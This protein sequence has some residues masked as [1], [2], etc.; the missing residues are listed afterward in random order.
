M[1]E[2]VDSL[3]IGQGLAGSLL[4]WRLLQRGERVVVVDN[5]H[6]SSSSTVAAG[7]INPVTG[8]RLVKTVGVDETLPVARESYREL[9]QLLGLELLVEKPMLRLFHSAQERERW[10]KRLTEEGYRPYLGEMLE[11]E[12]L[13]PPVTASHGGGRQ[14][15]TAYLRTTP[16]LHGLREWLEQ[17]QS[18]RQAQFD[19][20]ELKLEE[21]DVHWRDIHARRVI[22]CEGYKGAAN[23]WFG[24]LPFQPA[25]GEFLTLRSDTTLPDLII[26]SGRWLMPRSDGLYRAGASYDHEQLDETT[27]AE[28]RQMLL[29]ALPGFLSPAPEFEVVAQQAGV[30][31]TTSDRQ[32]FLGAHP[33]HSSVMIFN[34]FG[35][36]GSLLI[37]WHVERMVEWLHETKPLPEACDI[38]R[39]RGRFDD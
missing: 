35:S 25:K 10:Q 21:G 15:Q 24:T 4:A 19:Y 13:P 36:K 33:N 29:Q 16:L 32:P 20:G 34:G 26:N 9:E 37:P 7:L 28:A 3:I 1:T 38:E 14:L 12:E 22:F 6:R 11:P 2:Q 27:T 18:Y 39:Y 17:Q 5:A 31:P 8:K 30:R 23:P